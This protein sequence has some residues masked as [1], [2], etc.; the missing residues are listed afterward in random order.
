M[1]RTAVPLKTLVSLLVSVLILAT[2]VP[3]ADDEPGQRVN[4]TINA[5]DG[6]VMNGAVLVPGAGGSH[7]LISS[8]K[9]GSD[10]LM[11]DLPADEKALSVFF[12]GRLLSGSST[13]FV[14]FSDA[15]GERSVPLKRLSVAAEVSTLRLRIPAVAGARTLTVASDFQETPTMLEIASV[16]VH[17]GDPK[18]A[19]PRLDAPK[20]QLIA[21]MTEAI[22]TG[23]PLVADEILQRLVVQQFPDLNSDRASDWE[24]VK[25]IRQWAYENSDLAGSDS[26]KLDH[27][28]EFDFF[29]RRAIGI[30]AAYFKDR[31]GAYCGGT[32]IALSRLFDVFGFEAHTMSLGF[33]G[34]EDLTHTV[35]LV[36]ISHDGAPLTVIQDAYINLTYVD[37]DDEPTDLY[38][39]A[40]R[41][42]EGSK[43]KAKILEGQPALRDVLVASDWSGPELQRSS[44]MFQQETGSTHPVATVGESWNKFRTQTTHDELL[45]WAQPLL[46]KIEAKGRPRVIEQLFAFPF[47]ISGPH[48]DPYADRLEE[49]LPVKVSRSQTRR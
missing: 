33:P 42:A 44:W 9:P 5:K 38:V 16:E 20:D 19:Q 4:Q 48:P 41:L 21:A 15:R 46:D 40:Q 49:I 37:L 24:K 26:I 39:L 43:P 11:F 35:T 14:N 7:V 36:D 32:S 25:M 18:P 3:G 1:N 34:R 8:G 23:Y 22:E 12:Q 27:Q 45:T 13:I 10:S 17:P 2:S 28:P 30:F 47:N 29:N 6:V 31:G